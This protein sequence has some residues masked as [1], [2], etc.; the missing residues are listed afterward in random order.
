MVSQEFS[1][2]TQYQLSFF[3]ITVG[4]AFAYFAYQ[5]VDYAVIEVGLGGRLDATNVIQ[6]LLS[7][8]TNIGFDHTE[9]LGTSLAQIAYEKAGIIKTDIP[10][11]INADVFDF[12][13]TGFF[14]NAVR[15]IPEAPLV[16]Y[17]G[18]L[19]AG[20]NFFISTLTIS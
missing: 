13:L 6:P 20:S 2:T 11:V 14:I 7:V 1:H 5:E 8:I 19:T 3:E 15:S 18:N 12:M 9:F 16:L 10:V 17:S 4:M